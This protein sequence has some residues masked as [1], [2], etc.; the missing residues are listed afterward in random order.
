MS[1]SIG[2]QV[3]YYDGSAIVGTIVGP[4]TDDGVEAYVA[5]QRPDGSVFSPCVGFLV[6]VPSTNGGSMQSQ[7][8]TDLWVR[9]LLDP[10]RLPGERS[11]FVSH[12]TSLEV[13][14]QPPSIPPVSVRRISL[15]PDELAVHVP[16]APR[17]V[18]A[19]S[20]RCE[21]DDEC[22]GL[23]RAVEYGTLRDGDYVTQPMVVLIEREVAP[24]SGIGPVL[25][26][27][28][29]EVVSVNT[30]ERAKPLS[31][32]VIEYGPQ[33]ADVVVGT[34]PDTFGERR[35]AVHGDMIYLTEYVAAVEAD[36]PAEWH[37]ANVAATEWLA[38]D[39]TTDADDLDEAAM[40]FW[41]GQDEDTHLYLGRTDVDGMWIES[42]VKSQDE[43]RPMGLRRDV[44]TNDWAI[45]QRSYEV[46]R[47]R[48]LYEALVM[49]GVPMS[50]AAPWVKARIA[51]KRADA[52][53]E[54]RSKEKAS[55]WTEGFPLKPE[56][57]IRLA[58]YASCLAT[59]RRSVRRTDEGWRLPAS[60]R[61]STATPIAT[62]KYREEPTIGLTPRQRERLAARRR[63]FL[64]AA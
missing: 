31:E 8:I 48:E 39:V 25:L 9:W 24:A 20:C 44:V 10:H 47:R 46:K 45:D 18:V 34:L 30:R 43:D 50:K 60:F 32:R 62:T 12:R 35:L 11:S 38:Q 64:T 59:L 42:F 56:T 4:V 40:T 15:T 7:L 54:K 49:L 23:Y 37:Y 28:A 6:T 22:L 36:C 1:F 33:H 55:G 53:A 13:D 3:R 41:L 2:Q 21:L 58:A 19:A 27:Y 5:V 17:P 26:G 63:R 61:F 29:F 51:I 57:E 52:L 16:D 14:P